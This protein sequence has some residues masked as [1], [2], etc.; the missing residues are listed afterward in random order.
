M[1]QKKENKATIHSLK[2]VDLFA[3]LGSFRLAFE[4][5]GAECVFSSDNDKRVAKAY[6]YAHG[7]SCL[8]DIID[9]P[10]SDLPDFDILCAGFPCQPFSAAGEQL[11]FDD[12]RAA[13]AFK[14][15][16]IIRERQ[17]RAFVLENVKG[18][19]TH[20]DKLG[21]SPLNVL[22]SMLEACGYN[23]HVLLLN[24]YTHGGLPQ[25]RERYFFIGYRK[26]I[27]AKMR[28]E[29]P[30]IPCISSYKSFLQP[31]KSVASKYQYT[32]SLR[33]RISW[34]FDS[35]DAYEAD[36]SLADH[37]YQIRNSG[38]TVRKH[39]IKGRVPA[40]TKFMG[41]GGHNVPLVYAPCGVWRKLTPRECLSLQGY[42][43]SY[44]MHP[45][46]SDAAYYGMAGN[47]I[48]VTL[49]QRI[50]RLITASL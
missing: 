37:V 44:P 43:S 34:V 8:N 40:L 45:D 23:L 4:A 24:A 16:D 46:I 50:A 35:L 39:R 22:R 10:I 3:G 21:D 13:T 38:H 14:T 15:I 49:S 11:A 28:Q 48:P 12:P 29:L 26:D 7:E 19:Q 41:T 42:P 20:K 5:Q 18:I 32:R 27:Q 30:T 6:Q 2:F 9:Q 25:N 33:P 47:S 17:P 1:I 31:C 36:A